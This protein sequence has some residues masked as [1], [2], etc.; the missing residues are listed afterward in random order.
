MVKKFYNTDAP[1]AG[2]AA[3]N[4]A[5][6]MAKH[7]VMNNT[8]IP[9]ATPVTDKTEGTQEPTKPVEVT[10][11]ATATETLKSEQAIE[12]PPPT[13]PEAVQAPAAVQPNWQEVLRNQQPDD[14]LKTLGY[15]EKAVGFLK[16]F[17]DLDPKMQAFL[18]VWESGG[19]IKEYLQE[20]T[21]DYG[22]MSA[23]DV[24]R[25]QLRREYPKAS[26]QQ[27]DALYKREVVK[28]YSLDSLDDEEVE[29]G[30]A[31][32]EAK[33]EK[34]RESFV[35]SQQN[36]LLP[37]P[38]QKPDNS[39]AEA[40]A[41][42]ER[43][44]QFEAY[45]SQVTGHNLYREIS[46]AKAYTIGEGDEKFSFPVEPQDLQEVLFTDKWQE[47]MFDKDGNANV[48][49]QLL[50]ATVNKYGANFI[51]ELAKHFKSVGGQKAIEPIENASKPDGGTPAKSDAPP[52][53]PA[54][55]MARFGQVR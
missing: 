9:V 24:M 11:A 17:N 8:D 30:R 35:Q 15:D 18:N 21:T 51:K 4:V 14:V 12:T 43:V 45:K 3:P 47:N 52:Q 41:E 42:A 22:K 29:E 48:E 19:D 36:K 1:D 38:P 44:K 28:A 13:P 53:S 39:E 7:G 49:H 20:L 10:P 25:H 40:K 16:K 33:A 34:Y 54:E 37:Q 46:A 2:G 23:E 5:E 32:L 6:L 55:A 50:L 27:L 26:Q 31:L